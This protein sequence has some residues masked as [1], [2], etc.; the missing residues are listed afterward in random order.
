VQV[1]P[2]CACLWRCHAARRLVCATQVTLGFTTATAGSVSACASVAGLRISTTGS[3]LILVVSVVTICL[4]RV[5]FSFFMLCPEA[6]GGASIS[7]LLPGDRCD[8]SCAGMRDSYQR[9]YT[10]RN[11]GESCGRV[12]V[13]LRLV[14]LASNSVV[15]E[16]HRE[17]SRPLP[18]AKTERIGL[19]PELQASGR[20]AL[21]DSPQLESSDEHQQREAD[22]FVSCYQPAPAH[23]LLEAEQ[24]GIVRLQA[25]NCCSESA[26]IRILLFSF[27]VVSSPDPFR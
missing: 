13:V 15:K 27:L 16:K 4:L 5:C 14:S 10:R 3:V 23:A 12:L 7:L 8:K 17:C 18:I 6:A 11:N 20:N 26:G 1:I 25:A 9:G 24:R 19:E 22:K 2:T 21:R